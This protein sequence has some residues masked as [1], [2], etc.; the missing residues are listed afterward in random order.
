MLKA[1][2]CRMRA[3]FI[4]GAGVMILHLC[5]AQGCQARAPDEAPILPPGIDELC[6]SALKSESTFSQSIACI[7]QQVPR[8]NRAADTTVLSDTIKAPFASFGRGTWLLSTLSWDEASVVTKVRAD[9]REQFWK[10]MTIDEKRQW[11]QAF[12][13]ERGGWYRRLLTMTCKPCQG[14]GVLPSD[15]EH[16]ATCNQCIG[17][18]EMRVVEY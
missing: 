6:D 4:Q 13:I 1:S 14:K 12:A 10:Q 2:V 3:I 18:G 8:S 15:Q 5:L 11:L 17:A 16:Y 7:E 9:K